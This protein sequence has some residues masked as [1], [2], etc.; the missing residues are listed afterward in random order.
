VLTENQ[1]FRGMMRID[2]EPHHVYVFPV[3][4][5]AGTPIGMFFVAFS[6]QQTLRATRAQQRK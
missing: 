1:I 2:G 3:H 6:H 5:V 4:N